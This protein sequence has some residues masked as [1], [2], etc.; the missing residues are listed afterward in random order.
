MAPSLLS[1]GTP[2]PYKRLPKSLKTHQKVSALNGLLKRLLLSEPGDGMKLPDVP[3]FGTSRQLLLL[4]GVY[5]RMV[6]VVRGDGVALSLVDGVEN[7]AA[8]V[9]WCRHEFTISHQCTPLFRF[10]SLLQ[11]LVVKKFF[12]WP[13]LLRLNLT[14]PTSGFPA[15]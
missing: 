4:H 10:H 2:H 6:P 9:D 8:N 15:K 11:G 3:R 5:H 12:P 1:K 7:G 13:P 14:Y